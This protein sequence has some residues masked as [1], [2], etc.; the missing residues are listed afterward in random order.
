MVGMC[1]ILKIV[2]D[3]PKDRKGL[4]MRMNYSRA[5]EL[6]GL[7]TPKSLAENARLANSMMNSFTRQ[8][9]LRYKVA[10]SVVIRAAK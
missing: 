1:T 10:A 4:R 5:V 6:L 3:D 2:K 7:T 9:P 8:C